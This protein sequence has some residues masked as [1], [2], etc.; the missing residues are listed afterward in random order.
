MAC[1]KKPLLLKDD[2]CDVLVMQ[3]RASQATMTSPNER[4]RMKYMRQTNTNK[5]SHNKSDS[6][7]AV[8]V[9]G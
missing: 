3:I 2:E 8:S 5:Y 4:R 9:K 6:V 7:I 1:A